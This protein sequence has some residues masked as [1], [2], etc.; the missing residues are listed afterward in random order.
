MARG[1]FCL[2]VVLV[3]SALGCSS[4]PMTLVGY[5][6]PKR[7]QVA[8]VIDISSQADKQDDGGGVATLADA[9]TD[10]LKEHGIDSQ[11]YS[12]KYDH[13]KPP[14]VDIFV[15]YYHGTPPAVRWAGL[16]ALSAVNKIVLDCKVTLPG[17][18]KA[19]FSRHFERTSM[20]SSLTENADNA[21][22]ESVGEE[23]VDAIL[24]R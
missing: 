6:V 17:Q 7:Q 10:S 19:T 3:A 12:S 1:R 22:A 13:P 15:S 5:K 14:R 24:T 4:G 21:A 18:D 23:I 11:L 9:I 16:L 20:P 2:G 8:I